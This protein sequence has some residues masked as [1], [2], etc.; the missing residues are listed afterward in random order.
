MS[1]KKLSRYLDDTKSVDLKYMSY[2]SEAMMQQSPVMS[3][4]LLWVA[5]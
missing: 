1:L 4:L 3:R 5:F 2:S